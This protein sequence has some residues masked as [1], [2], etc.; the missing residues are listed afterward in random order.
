[1]SLI[2][3]LAYAGAAVLGVTYFAWRMTSRED[4]AGYRELAASVGL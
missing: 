2:R 3:S 1:M 4:A